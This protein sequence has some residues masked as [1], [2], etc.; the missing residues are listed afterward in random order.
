MSYDL[1]LNYTIYTMGYLAILWDYVEIFHL[2][3]KVE[4]SVMPLI[5]ILYYFIAG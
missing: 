5:I 3:P 2:S 4:Q 1:D